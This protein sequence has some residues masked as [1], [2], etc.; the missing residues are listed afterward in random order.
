VKIR[1]AVDD[2]TG[3]SATAGTVTQVLFA[4]VIGAFACTNL[5]PTTNALSETQIDVAYA[6]AMQAT[7]NPSDVSKTINV[8]F[9]ARQ[10][11]ACRVNLKQNAIV[12]SQGGM[13]GRMAV[14]RPP[15]GITTA[16]ALSTTTQPGVG[17]YRDQRVIYCFPGV[18]SVVNAI[19]AVGTAGG[20]G[21]TAT[22]QVDQGADGWLAS[23]L[24]NLPPEENPG[25]DT[26]FTTLAVSLESAYAAGGSM[27]SLQTSDYINFKAGG[28]CAPIFDFSTGVMTFQSGITS[29]DP[30][31]NPGLVRIARR[32]MA[33]LIEDS[34][35]MKGPVVKK[36]S[37]DMRR[38]AYSS[39]VR[40]FFEQL[41]SRKAPEAARIAGYT[42]D[43][44]QRNDPTSVGL[45]LYYLT[46]KVRT[47][48][49]LD[50]IVHVATV[51]D[52]VDVEEKLPQAA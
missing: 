11:N 46:W 51:G 17:A 42:L 35:A 1:H 27:T 18:A 37:T 10:S 24:S 41:L 50:S 52:T 30:I 8:I 40:Q 14:V 45:G 6:T 25:Q 9:S 20:Q 36:L 19:A 22:G 43:V 28:I 34:V 21:F 15:L 38:R 33:D 12:A 2:G 4:P 44:K 5:L 23:I 7:L 39:D 16:T 48:S 29:V 3:T 31:A 32:R 13:L 49:S 26:E 47:L